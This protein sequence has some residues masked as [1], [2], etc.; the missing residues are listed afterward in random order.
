CVGPR[1]VETCARAGIRVLAFEAGL[2]VLLD[3][4]EAEA[5]ARREGVS[6]LGWREA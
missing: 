3:R 2:T 5:V 6:L 4:P 1:T